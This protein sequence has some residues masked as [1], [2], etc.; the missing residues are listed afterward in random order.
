MY[1]YVCVYD[2]FFII[3]NELWIRMHI[4][5][6]IFFKIKILSP[7]QNRKEALSYALSAKERGIKII[8]VGDGV[9]AHLSGT[10]WIF[11]HIYLI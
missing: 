10:L 1:L 7:H 2:I 9:E 4:I 11:L 8:I 3:S 5:K 6:F